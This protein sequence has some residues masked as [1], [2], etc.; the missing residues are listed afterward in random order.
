MRLAP[1]GTGRKLLLT[2]QLL[3][4]NWTRSQ[5]WWSG[6]AVLRTRSALIP[7][8]NALPCRGPALQARS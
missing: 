8:A 1:S 2:E 7:E 6:W 4:E 5:E 3:A